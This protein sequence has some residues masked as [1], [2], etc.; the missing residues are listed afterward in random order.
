M[1]GLDDRAQQA[2]DTDAIAAHMDRTLDPIRA[3]NDGLHGHGIFLTEIE[4]M[5]DL[6]AAR[7]QAHLFWHFGLKAGGIMHLFGR[8]IERSALINQMLQVA[9]PVL[10]GARR[11]HLDQ[12]AVTEDFALAR[13]GQNDELVAQITADRTCVS[14]HRHDL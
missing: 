2:R 4:D 11:A 13:I 12:I 3:C 6:D 7:G 1:A 10:I 9:V 14:A 5:A 8:G